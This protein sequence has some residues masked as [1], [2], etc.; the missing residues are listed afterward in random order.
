MT[1]LEFLIEHGELKGVKADNVL[2]H[3]APDYPSA[4]FA[5]ASIELAGEVY[6]LSEEELRILTDLYQGL[7]V[8][9]PG[10]TSHIKDTQKH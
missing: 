6:Q 7:I 4:V 9:F 2:E 8:E 5:A 3:E 10:D 1:A